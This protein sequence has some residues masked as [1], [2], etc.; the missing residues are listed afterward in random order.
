LDKWL[1][2]IWL[3]ANAKNGISSYELSRAIGITQKSAWHVLHRIRLA[4]QNGSINKLRGSVEVD[5][6]LQGGKARNMHMSRRKH[7]GSR[8]TGKVAVMGLLERN[9]EVRTMVVSGTKRRM[10]HGEVSKHVEEGSTVYSDALRSYNQL[11]ET[12][13]HNVINHAVEYVNGH[14]HTN[15]IENFWSLLKR[16][17][18]GTYISVEPFHLFRYLDEQAFRFNKRKGTDSSRFMKLVSMITGKRLEYKDL[19]GRAAQS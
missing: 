13:I 14:I 8:E 11:G 19:I 3:I 2:A 12:Y 1:V 9:G 16:S 6:T 5:E 18:K 15:G 4:M 7:L 17:L 10:L